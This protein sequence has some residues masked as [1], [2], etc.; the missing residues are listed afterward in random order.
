MSSA[1]RP[2]QLSLPVAQRPPS[3]EAGSAPL[4]N[5]G[6]SG[7]SIAWPQHSH[8]LYWWRYVYRGRW[9]C[10]IC[11]ARG[12]GGIWHCNLCQY[13]LCT[14]CHP[15]PAQQPAWQP[16]QPEAASPLSPIDLHLQWR[17]TRS[18]PLTAERL[19]PTAKDS[20]RPLPPSA[21]RHQ[22]GSAPLSSLSSL[23]SSSP[24]QHLQLPALRGAIL[25]RI[26]FAWDAGSLRLLYCSV[27]AMMA[28]LNTT[29][30]V[31]AHCGR[32]LCWMQLLQAALYVLL[33]AFVCMRQSGSR[34]PVYVVLVIQAASMRF[35]VQTG[36]EL[37]LDCRGTA[38]HPLIMTTLTL[39]LSIPI[40]A[41]LPCMWIALLDCI[42]WYRR[43][44][45]TSSQSSARAAT[46]LPPSLSLSMFCCAVLA[47]VISDNALLLHGRF[48]W[49][50][51]DS[52]MLSGQLLM[53]NWFMLVGVLAFAVVLL[54]R[55]WLTDA[56]RLVVQQELRKDEHTVAVSLCSLAM[57]VV[58]PPA[59][60]VGVVV[61]LNSA[62]PWQ[63]TPDLLTVATVVQLL[64]TV[65]LFATLIAWLRRDWLELMGTNPARR[66]LRPSL[67][68]LFVS[69][70]LR[71][72]RPLSS[73]TATAAQRA[74]AA[75]KYKTA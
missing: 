37:L 48:T 27:C 50:P 5:D 63:R 14:S 29:S 47:L 6:D 55:A 10:N 28:A 12:S 26:G 71:E 53:G 51:A 16:S 2:A 39:D 60:I 7:P 66:R 15:A 54:Q 45:L 8:R 69:L 68:R 44:L 21:P 24:P 40:A 61:L 49:R 59:T 64:N 1:V 41:F 58:V 57:F 36:C 62:W 74:M 34:W 17:L 18:L 72:P 52:A 42:S 4:P 67:R 13:D 19:S 46:A 23:S 73:S 11:R 9:I 3:P 56:Q 33:A 35:A 32:V 22:R 65:C 30:I 31:W 25:P 70:M 75:L 43:Q 38:P 20:P